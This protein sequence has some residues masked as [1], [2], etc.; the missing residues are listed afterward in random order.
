[1][2]TLSAEKLGDW[3]TTWTE[4][5]NEFW[6]V[7]A[8]GVGLLHKD[9]ELCP[10]WRIDHNGFFSCTSTRHNG[11]SYGS[12]IGRMLQRAHAAGALPV[13]PCGAVL[14][15]AC[16]QVIDNSHGELEGNLVD[17]VDEEDKRIH[18]ALWG[19]VYDE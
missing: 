11:E 10:G 4:F 2:T 14:C 18:R 19:S 17:C 16:W 7:D 1:M 13:A 3:W 12:R 6:P 8:A 9:G 5:L 15:V